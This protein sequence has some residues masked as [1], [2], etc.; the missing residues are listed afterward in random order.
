[1]FA[2]NDF[3]SIYFFLY[4]F[5]LLFT[6]IYLL[7]WF[8]FNC[9]LGLACLCLFVWLL[10]ICSFVETCWFKCSFYRCLCFY[11][12]IVFV[13]VLID[14]FHACGSGIC[15][16]SFVCS[17]LLSVCLWDLLCSRLL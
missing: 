10:V 7:I 13:V 3:N 11:C 8:T 6:I 5:R 2:Y 17:C 15:G 12:V 4:S 9:T 14:L 16:T 1:M